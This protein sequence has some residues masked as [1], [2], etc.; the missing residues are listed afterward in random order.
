MVTSGFPSPVEDV[1]VRSQWLLCKS[2]LFSPCAPESRALTAAVCLASGFRWDGAAS[3]CLLHSC[4]L[5]GTYFICSGGVK[6][7]FVFDAFHLS[8]ECGGFLRPFWGC[9]AHTLKFHCGRMSH[10]VL[11]SFDFRWV[12]L[13]CCLIWEIICILL[14]ASLRSWECILCYDVLLSA[15]CLC[16]AHLGAMTFRACAGV[17][18]I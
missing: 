2:L 6:S 5:E 18:I 7:T 15:L 1:W 16:P 11:F 8:I 9:A 14:E 10:Y 4:P 13:F 17:V 12:S 3:R